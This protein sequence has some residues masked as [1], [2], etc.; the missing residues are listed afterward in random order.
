M[1]DHEEEFSVVCFFSEEQYCYDCRY[2]TAEAAVLRSKQITD[3]DLARRG[4]ISRVMITD[5]DG[6]TAF[7]WEHGKGVVY[8][9]AEQLKQG[10]MR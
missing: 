2:V 10:G 8:P 6:Y 1:V 5:G 9:T 7:L 4:I 3:S